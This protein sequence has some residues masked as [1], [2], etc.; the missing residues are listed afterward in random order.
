[1]KRLVA[2]L[3]MSVMVA[4]SGCGGGSSSSSAPPQPTILNGTVSKGLIQN[5]WVK[6]YPLNADGT[7]GTTPLATVR[8][9]LDGRYSAD[10]GSYVGPVIAI[11]YGTYTD[12]ATNTQITLTES[13]PLRAALPTASGNVTLPITALTEV[14]VVSAGTL[15]PS[16]IQSS[17]TAVATA[18]KVDIVGSEPVAP[19]AATLATATPAQRDYTLA[20]AALSQMAST[21]TGTPTQQL[22][23][24]VTT[25]SSGVSGTTLTTTVATTFAGAVNDYLQA[26][27][28]T[29]AVI[30]ENGGSQVLTVGKDT[31]KLTIGISG[32][33]TGKSVYGA[34]LVLTLPAGVTVK[35]Q[36]GSSE[37]LAGTVAL[38]GISGMVDGVFTPA[39][40]GAPAT[41]RIIFVSNSAITGGAVL[42]VNA[43]L[44]SG[45]TVAKSSFSVAVSQAEDQNINTLSGVSASVTSVD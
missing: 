8:T 20:L 5:G 40:N 12:E 25:L 10:I 34:D 22:Q 29:N 16:H 27:T 33:P 23:S 31:A 24:T 11:G 39:A 37:V 17:N 21:A 45:I 44:S 30:S 4:L 41:L 14:A 13:N 38:A 3:A 1:M 2:F 35:T 15:T 18:F 32:V 36:T 43:D 6:I 7:R 9:G 19:D 28:D 42:T 26:N